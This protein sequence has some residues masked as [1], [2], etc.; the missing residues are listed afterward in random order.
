MLGCVEAVD[1][2]TSLWKQK[3]KVDRNQCGECSALPE[4]QY[5]RNV[6]RSSLVTL[7]SPREVPQIL[8]AGTLL[9]LVSAILRPGCEVKAF[10][11]K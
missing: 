2:K 4:Q 11:R 1:G 3:E 7:P 5:V 10:W 9:E 8:F 6:V